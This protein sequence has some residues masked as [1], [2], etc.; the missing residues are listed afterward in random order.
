M[1]LDEL[2]KIAGRESGHG[3]DVSREGVQ[4]DI[5][6]IVEGTTVNTRHGFVRTDHI[7]F[8]A[9]GAFH[10][11]NPAD[12]IPELQG[13]F[14][15]RVEL[16]L[17]LLIAI[18]VIKTSGDI[19]QDRPLSEA[20]G[21][22]LFTKEIED[23]LLSGALAEATFTGAAAL[24]SQSDD[25]LSV[26]RERVTSKGGT[27]YAAL[28]HLEAADVKSVFVAAMRAADET[29]FIV[30]EPLESLRHHFQTNAAP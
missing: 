3:P 5:L 9:A 29:G 17:V 12:L 16:A 22:G 20:G 23:A 18:T 28:T 25:A 14:P 4:R 27:T 11:S 10:V 6:P 2:D 7:L 19:I 21:K 30:R 1:F 24:A 15:I 13:R 8:I 26:L